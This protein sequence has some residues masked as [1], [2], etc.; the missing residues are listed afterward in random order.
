MIKPRWITNWPS[1]AE[2]LQLSLPCQRIN[3]RKCLNSS[4][5]KSLAREA[6]FPSLPTIPTPTFA[7]RIIPTSLPPSPTEQVLFPVNSPILTVTRAFYVGLHLQTQTEGAKVAALKK[8]SSNKGS[9]ISSSRVQPSII[10][11]VLVFYSNS[12]S[13]A[14]ASLIVS[15][16]L[17]KNICWRRSLKPAEMAMHKAV[18]TLSPV[19]I[20]TYIPPARSD[21]IVTAT[22]F[23][24]LSKL[25]DQEK[26]FKLTFYTCN[27]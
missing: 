6:C 9:D 22:S 5:E 25:G 14:L 21:S 24:N 4:I 16:S 19:S 2:R 18:S 13:L 8:R 11:S 23:C 1:T 27:T 26:E 3:L 20:Q 10:R 17:M 12:S 7:S 15:R